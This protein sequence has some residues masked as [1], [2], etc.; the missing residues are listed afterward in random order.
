MEKP[1]VFTHQQIRQ[2]APIVGL[3]LLLW[4]GLVAGMLFLLPA[5]APA[6]EPVVMP[7]SPEIEERWGV[8]IS[9]IGVTAD[10]GLVD[11]RFIVIDPDKALAMLQNVEN[12]PVLVAED[13]GAIVNSMAMMAGRHSLQPGRTYF[14]LYRNTLGAIKP[15]SRV[16]VM[17]NNSVTNSGQALQIEHVQAQ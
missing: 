1:F 3:M 10:G 5:P 16:K 8:R 13:T 11:F 7:V 4:A 9:Q 17:F 12:L 14:L 15:G 2:F 6:P